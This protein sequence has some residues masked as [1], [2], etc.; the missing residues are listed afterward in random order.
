M[1]AAG[2]GLGTGAGSPGVRTGGYVAVGI[3]LAAVVVGT[4]V[5][6]RALRGWWRLLVLPVVLAALLA[7]DVLAV[8]LLA[9][10]GP[11]PGAGARTPADVGLTARDVVVPTADGE[12]LAGW[13]VPTRTGAAVVLL[14]GSGSSRAAVLDHAAV[15]AGHGY[16]VLAVDARG[17]GDSTGR[18]MRWGWN[19]EEDVPATITHLLA[20]GDVDA[21]RVA[22]VGL[23]MGGEEAIGAAARDP[24]VAAVV[25]EGVTG[26]QAADLGWLSDVYGW[27]GAVQEV[28]EAGQTAVAAALTPVPE[29]VP[30]RDAV[31]LAAPRPVLL[32]AAG[33]VPDEQHAATHLTAAAPG[34]VET[35]VVPGA[36]HT[37][38]L[39]TDPAGWERRVLAFLDAAT[40][41]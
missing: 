3:G 38:A 34:T 15:L 41:G 40:A 6:L 19:G 37:G 16:G 32:V 29:P 35:W 1:L 21:G 2:L 10:A 18:P 31:R 20:Q 11:R 26:R 17:H 5:L 12:R 39:A 14:H 22:V 8:G 13:Y 30:L 24:R 4:V 9:A 36:G 33:E 27:R 25:A 28:L 7:V 23:S